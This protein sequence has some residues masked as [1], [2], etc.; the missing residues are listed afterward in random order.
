MMIDF[1]IG[2]WDSILVVIL[3]I[4]GILFMI[5]RGATKQVN[6]ILFYLVTE[7][8][9]E[10][11]NGTGSLKYAA[12]TTW[13]YER[14][15]SVIKILFTSKQIDLMI[16]KAVKEMKDYLDTNSNAKLLIVD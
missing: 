6:E 7:A 12:V 14:L 15:P 4:I 5:K 8:E 16:E 9:R 3:F 11:G 10:F 13:L 2:N 1:I